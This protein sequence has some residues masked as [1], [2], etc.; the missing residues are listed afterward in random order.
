[1]YEDM[2]IN[3]EHMMALIPLA[4][5]EA[6][7]KLIYKTSWSKEGSYRTSDFLHRISGCLMGFIRL[8]FFPI[9][10]NIPETNK[11]VHEDFNGIYQ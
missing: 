5:N 8:E 1:M 4:P 10:V 3:K 9:Y 7:F 6:R 2:G 11:S